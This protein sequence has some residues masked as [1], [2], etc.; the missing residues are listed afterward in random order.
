MRNIFDSSFKKIQTNF[1]EMVNTD[2]TTFIEEIRN[3][4][5]PTLSVIQNNLLSINKFIANNGLVP[6]QISNG[7]DIVF[8]KSLSFKSANENIYNPNRNFILLVIGVY[9]VLFILVVGLVF[10]LVTNVKSRRL[11]KSEHSEVN[12]LHNLPV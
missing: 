8:A 3:I 2:R 4:L 11:F 9:G 5:A 10:Y 6:K 12:L 1:H 7:S